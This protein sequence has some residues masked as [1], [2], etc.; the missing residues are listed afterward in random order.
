MKN[1][2]SLSL[3]LSAL[4]LAG[5]ARAAEAEV[6]AVGFDKLASFEFVAPEDP[7]KAA[8]AE[9]QIPAKIRE[10]NEIKKK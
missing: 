10:Y 7:A 4:C 6:L 2:V 5:V 9:A 3:L 1:K 8:A